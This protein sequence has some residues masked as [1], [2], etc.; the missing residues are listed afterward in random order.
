M[1]Y[2]ILIV[3][4]SM[5]VRAA[6]KRIIGMVDIDTNHIYEASNGCEALQKL[7]SENIDI[8]LA[9]LNMP[10]MNGIELIER[11]Q[12]DNRL[13]EIP[14]IIISTESSST[15]IEDLMEKG[16]KGFL[17]K[18]FSPEEFRDLITKHV[19]VSANAK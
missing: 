13:K 18:P 14:A 11:M 1:S 5:L 6:I 2:N 12:K 4:D 9:D 16:I 7:E 10:E 3:D 8:V 15:R 17:H 19:G